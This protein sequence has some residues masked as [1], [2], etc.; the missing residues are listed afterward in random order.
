MAKNQRAQDGEAQLAEM[1][2]TLEA[3]RTQTEKLEAVT[4]AAAR[5][6][7]FEEY[8]LERRK[9]LRR[10]LAEAEAKAQACGLQLA[11]P[12]AEPVA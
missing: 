12:A 2:A 7:E 8:L 9:K 6:R 4:R 10:E 11:A 3:L 5:L 1:K